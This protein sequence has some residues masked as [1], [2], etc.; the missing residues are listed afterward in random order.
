MLTLASISIFF[1]FFPWYW[2]GIWHHFFHLPDDICWINW[3]KWTINKLC[4]CWLMPFKHVVSQILST[5]PLLHLQHVLK[6]HSLHNTL[7]EKHLEKIRNV[8]GG[9][10]IYTLGSPLKAILC[11]L[12][13]SVGTLRPTSR[14]RNHPLLSLIV[15]IYVCL[16]P[17][18]ASSY[19]GWKEL[20]S[21]W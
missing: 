17:C 10:L 2:V 5:L 12:L 11:L 13:K 18:I 7:L 8:F 20:S 3:D 6:P 4:W 19:G 14:C 21:R 9:H 1:I 15:M 16:G